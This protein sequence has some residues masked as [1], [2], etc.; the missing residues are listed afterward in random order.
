MLIKPSCVHERKYFSTRVK[1]HF[2]EMLPNCP[3][4][5]EDQPTMIIKHIR[6]ELCLP[7]LYYI[8]SD[9][10]EVHLVLSTVR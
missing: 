3:T 1:N 2:N 9:E 4:I 7:L 6:E 10:C 8:N 5:G